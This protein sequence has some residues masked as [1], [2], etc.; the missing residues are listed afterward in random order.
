M[1]ILSS[2]STLLLLVLAGAAFGL[3]GCSGSVD[4]TGAGGGGD[5]TNSGGGGSGGGA[6]VACETSD[7]CDAGA[8]CRFADH[9]CGQ[10]QAS[11]TCTGLPLECGYVPAL[12]C[13]CD[14]QVER[15]DCPELRRVDISANGACT[16]P[17]GTFACGYTF[18]QTGTE[19]CER[20]DHATTQ[21]GLV[22]FVCMQLPASCD[23]NDTCACVEGIDTPCPQ[24]SCETDSAGHAVL[25]CVN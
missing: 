9:G 24:T 6:A 7:D 20:I 25:S 4:S 21:P 12:V 13:A 19:F 11:G 23:G 15:Q 8:F 18:C 1:T 16:P 10:G 3:A 17:E 22:R 5:E 14:G 2:R